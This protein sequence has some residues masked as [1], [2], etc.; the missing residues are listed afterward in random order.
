MWYYFHV[1]SNGAAFVNSQSH[2]EAM[3]TVVIIA[4]RVLRF[5]KCAIIC[6][7]IMNA[8][9]SFSVIYGLVY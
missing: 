6:S 9:R 7:A 5:Q 1:R 4:E 8:M 2:R 3:Q